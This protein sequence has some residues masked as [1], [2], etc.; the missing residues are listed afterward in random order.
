MTIDLNADLGEGSGDDA[1]LLTIVTS[2]SIACGGHAGAD[3]EISAALRGA[4]ANGVRIGAHPG[5]ADRANFGRVRL[6][7]PVTE[8]LAQVLGQMEHFLALALKADAE[9]S[10]VKLH[11]ALANMTAEDDR[12]AAEIYGAIRTR[13]GPL[14]VMALEHSGQQRAAES[15]DLP[16]IREA[17]AD[18]AYMPGGQLAPRAMEGSVIEDADAIVS[19][20][21]RLATKGEIVAIDGTVLPSN[22]QSI[23]LHGDTPGALALA[24]KVRIAL[25]RAG[26][27]A[28]H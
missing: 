26:L 19:R 23:C 20:C 4:K 28:S 21:L 15:L 2:A 12:F 22:A 5:F 11:G 18:R 14:A 13:F 6:N 17:Y 10:Y 3:N 7:L 27:M 16:V 8:I 24:K 25:E 9:V 1:A